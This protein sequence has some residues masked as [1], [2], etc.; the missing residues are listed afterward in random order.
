MR[1][2]SFPLRLPAFFKTWKDFSFSV[3]ESFFFQNSR[4]VSFQGGCDCG[5]QS[6]LLPEELH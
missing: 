2:E 5:I 6:T 4:E 1:C 3:L